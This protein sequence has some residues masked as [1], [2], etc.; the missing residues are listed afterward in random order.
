MAR[1]R[2]SQREKVY[3]SERSTIQNMG[4][5]DMTIEE[6]QAYI[7]KITSQKWF[8]KNFG[9]SWGVRVE[10]G[11]G[12]GWALGGR[13]GLI[14]LGVWARREPVVLHELTHLIIT[15]RHNNSA[16]WHGWEFCAVYLQLVQH[17]MGRDAAEALK[18]AYKGNKVRFRAP[19]KRKPLT[20]EQKAVL[21]DRLAVARAAKAAKVD[22]VEES[23]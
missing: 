3:R 11:R 15:N 21:R 20:E 18:S 4:R 16:A 14:T 2:D 5:K 13:Y 10:H 1:P 17:Y 12:G 8:T 7:D 23:S 9:G 22:S 6:C 19:R